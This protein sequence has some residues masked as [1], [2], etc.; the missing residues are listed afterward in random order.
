MVSTYVTVGNNPTE[1]KR[2][3]E[4]EIERQTIGD[5]KQVCDERMRNS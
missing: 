2:K 5:G 3:R 4:L 1:Q